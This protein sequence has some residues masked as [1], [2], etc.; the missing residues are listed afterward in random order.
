MLGHKLVGKLDKLSQKCRHF[1]EKIQPAAR[2]HRPPLAANSHTCGL[3]SVF[4]EVQEMNCPAGAR[5]ATLGCA[6]GKN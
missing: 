3:R 5:E 4:P 6:P 2:T 1:F